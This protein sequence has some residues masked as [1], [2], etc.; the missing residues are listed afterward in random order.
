MSAKARLGLVVAYAFVT[1]WAF[2]QPVAGRVLDFGSL[3]GWLAPALLVLVVRDLSPGRAFRW[4]FGAGLVAHTA[5]IHW[6]YV[7]TVVYGNAPVVVGLVAPALL[8]GYCALFGGL[9]G[10]AASLLARRG[11]AWPWSLAAVWTVLDHLRAWEFPWGTLGYVQHENPALLPLAAWGGV[12][13]LSFVTVLGG[14]ALAALV[15]GTDTGGRRA[16]A[17]AL[18]AVVAAHGLGLVLGASE[19]EQGPTVRVAVLQGNIDQGV[20]WSRGWA[21]KTLALYEDLTRRAAADGARVVAWPETA[22]PGVIEGSTALRRRL[23]RLAAETGADLVVGG[24]GVAYQGEP[25]PSA[26]FDS[27]Y[28]VSPT[29]GFTDRYDKVKLVPFGEY[30]PFRPLLGLFIGA[31]AS[32][33]TS[34]DVSPGERPRAVVLEDAGVPAG[35]VVCYELLFPD[36]VRRFAADGGELLLA[37]TNDAWYGR[38]GAPYQFLAMTAL[39]SAETGLWTARA[40]N[41]GVS[42]FI[43]GRGRVR[44]RTPIFERAWRV[45]DVPRHPS[46]REATFYV[47]H[48]DVFAGLCWVAVLGL[49]VAGR[50]RR[51]AAPDVRDAGE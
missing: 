24:V 13:A 37:I 46:P 41:T 50:L 1:F 47:R 9:F 10:L 32:G 34:L 23:E 40:A 5:L 14:A 43:D 42:G 7:V 48:G 6:I 18:A 19:P 51:K 4:G 49:A 44:E 38:T 36:L 16:A 30:V 25:R 20:K 11:L 27:G 31:V 26:Y 12:Y 28:V 3:L 8:A 2:P 29:R 21:E 22:V 45:A 39:R 17:I 35:V 33:A 15:P